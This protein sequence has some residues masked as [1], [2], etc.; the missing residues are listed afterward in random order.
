MAEAMRVRLQELAADD[1]VRALV[2]TGDDRT[3]CAGVDLRSEEAGHQVPLGEVLELLLEDIWC[4]PVPTVAL[5]RGP[6]VGVGVAIATACDVRIAHPDATFAVP[7][8]RLGIRYTE[9]SLRR[10]VGLTGRGRANLALLG[11]RPVAADQA[12]LWGLVDSCT[13]NIDGEAQAFLDSVVEVDSDVVRATREAIRTCS[14][15]GMPGA[16][17]GG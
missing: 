2:V 4:F 15:E 14:T 6:C 17:V 8:V 1:R 10:L 16:G 5:V 13:V 11:G 7:G 12:A 3:F 9:A